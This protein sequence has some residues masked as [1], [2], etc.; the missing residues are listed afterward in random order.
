[1]C[2]AGS[3]YCKES[4]LPTAL[5]AYKRKGLAQKG[6]GAGASP[7]WSHTQLRQHCPV[8]CLQQ[9]RPHT[10]VQYSIDHNQQIIHSTALQRCKATIMAQRHKMGGCRAPQTMC[11]PMLRIVCQERVGE[12]HHW[13][14]TES[15][16]SRFNHRQ[17]LAGFET[18]SQA[19]QGWVSSQCGGG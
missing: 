5:V 6:T 16:Y 2:K 4:S 12:Q 1:M 15:S 7:F 14:I 10:S 9:Q 18:K 8:G 19:T 3:A 11:T 13:C 17:C